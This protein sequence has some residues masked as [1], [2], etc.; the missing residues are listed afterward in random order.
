[1]KQITYSE[2]KSLFNIIFGGGVQSK[3]TVKSS[4][5][6]KQPVAQVV[7][8][9][10]KK[11]QYMYCSNGSYQ[12]YTN[13]QFN[14]PN[15]GFTHKSPDYCAQNNQGTETQLANAPPTT[16]L[17]NST[18]TTQTAAIRPPGECGGYAPYFNCQQQCPDFDSTVQIGLDQDNTAYYDT[19]QYNK[20]TETPSY[21]NSLYQDYLIVIK[22]DYNY[23]IWNEGRTGCPVTLVMPPLGAE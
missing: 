14:N 10:T 2:P 5:I 12:S 11:Y 18:A 6:T 21:Y 17:N 3:L 8:S 9:G 7:S 4:H 20:T 1:M 19:T 23:G 22:A 15:T 13:A 16:Q